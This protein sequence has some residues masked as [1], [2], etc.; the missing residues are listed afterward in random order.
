M[1][2]ILS[3][4]ISEISAALSFAVLL[5]TDFGSYLKILQQNIN[6]PIPIS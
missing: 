6:T 3:V 4:K 5:H 1:E 2:Y